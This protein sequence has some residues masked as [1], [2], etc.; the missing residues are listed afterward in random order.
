MD[1]VNSLRAGFMGVVGLPNAGKSSLVNALVQ[2]KVSIVTP[3]P[4][5]TRRRT[6]GVVTVPEGQIL[7]IDA[8]GFIEGRKGLNAFL[9]QEVE[10][11]IR[12]SDALMIVLNPDVPKFSDLERFMELVLKTQKKRLFVITKCDLDSHQRKVQK[13]KDRVVRQDPTALVFEVKNSPSHPL[14]EEKRYQIIQ[15][16]LNLLPESS[17]YLYDGEIF[18]PHPVREIVAELIRETC[19]EK[20]HQELPYELAVRMRKYEEEK[21]LDRIYADIVVAREGQKKIV[22]GHGGGMVKGIG[23]ESRKKIEAFLGKQ[24]YLS[25]QVVVREDWMNHPIYLRE[26]GYFVRKRV[27]FE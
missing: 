9:E 25:L 27:T 7:L 12:E 3:K 4:Q 11:V 14:T 26:M 2:E 15:A 1:H 13:L 18:T 10:E 20:L 23:I 16:S 22:V 6:I 24:V 5:T 21:D 8:P 17:S 19:F